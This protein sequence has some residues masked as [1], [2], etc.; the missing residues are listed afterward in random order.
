V[1]L[2]SRMVTNLYSPIHFIRYENAAH[3]V[4]MHHRQTNQNRRKQFVPNISTDASL[5]F[6]AQAGMFAPPRKTVGNVL[7][8]AVALQQRF[9]RL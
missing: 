9:R 6:Q 3:Q 4:L 8:L 7:H 2:L 5:K 1:L